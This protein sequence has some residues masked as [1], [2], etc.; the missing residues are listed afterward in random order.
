MKKI[1]LTPQEI[2]VIERQIAGEIDGW[3]VTPEEREII[4]KV[5]N[6]AEALLAELDDYDE[7][8]EDL[9]AWYYEKYKAQAAE[10]GAEAAHTD[11]V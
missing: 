7:M 8:G 10:G 4:T 2:D 6:E 9:V 3:A 11:E 5:V 1:V